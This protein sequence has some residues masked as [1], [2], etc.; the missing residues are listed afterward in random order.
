MPGHEQYT[1][2]TY[3][4]NGG[5]GPHC[6]CFNLMLIPLVSRFGGS[7]SQSANGGEEK[8]P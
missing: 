4:G 8:Y 3:R 2:N 7:Y 5:Q 1:V 6:S